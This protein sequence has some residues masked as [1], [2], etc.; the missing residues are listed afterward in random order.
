M[1]GKLLKALLF[2]P[3]DSDLVESAGTA[4]VTLSLIE[5]AHLQQCFNELLTQSDST[6]FAE[7]LS[8]TFAKFNADLSTSE[9]I[10]NFQNS[11]A[12]IPSPIDG[13]LLRQPLFEFLV[14][15]RAVL[16]V[17]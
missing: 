3:F 15:T 14:N 1:L 11:T 4:L 17:K 6:T 5:P 16:R 13:T 12:P 7:R 2:S 9:A 10:S 8:A